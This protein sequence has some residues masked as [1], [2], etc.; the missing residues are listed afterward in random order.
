MEIT[1]RTIPV[2]AL[3]IGLAVAYAQVLQAMT[4]SATR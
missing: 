4:E 1:R 3:G 2:G